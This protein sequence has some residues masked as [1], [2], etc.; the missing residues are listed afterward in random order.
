MRHERR[1]EL[2]LEGFRWYDLVRWGIAKETIL[3]Y[4]KTEDRP[5]LTALGTFTSDFLPIPSN[6]IDIT[7]DDGGN[8]TLVQNPGY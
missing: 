8:P 1:L 5:L 7:R 6:Q 2:A 3:N 4:F